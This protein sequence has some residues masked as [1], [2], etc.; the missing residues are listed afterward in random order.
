MSR[1][2]LIVAT[3][4][5]GAAALITGLVLED[6]RG[7]Y[8][9]EICPHNATV[10]YDS[11][12][13]YSDYLVLCNGTDRTVDLG[14][15]GLSDDKTVLDKY[16]LPNVELEPG[17]TLTVWAAVPDNISYDYVDTLTMYTNFGLRDHEMLFLSD[18]GGVV[19]D[20]VRLPK[21]EKDQAYMYHQVQ[22]SGQEQTDNYPPHFGQTPQKARYMAY[23]CDKDHCRQV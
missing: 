13:H 7:V 10:I 3:I 1:I 2:T 14:G 5:L 9:S 8:F 23:H 12:G 22:R 18:P 11:V 17:E 21:L 15:Y 16:V 4:L 20:S 19:V 6:N